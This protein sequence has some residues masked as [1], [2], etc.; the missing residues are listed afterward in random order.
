MSDT[1]FKKGEKPGPGRPPGAQNKLTKTLKEA[2]L[3]AAEDVGY[4]GEGDEGLVGYLKKVAKEDVKA[5]S[6]L[7]GKVLPMT[8]ANPDG[9]AFRTENEW[10]VRLV[11]ANA[12]TDA[13]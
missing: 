11:R 7:L 8:V 10:T 1:Q 13:P 3:Q 6:S 12:G 9:E 5:F 4:D 2:I